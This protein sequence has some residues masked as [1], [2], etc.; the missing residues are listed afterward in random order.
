MYSMVLQV[1]GSNFNS[2]EKKRRERTSEKEVGNLDQMIKDYRHLVE[3]QQAEEVDLSK[4]L[5]VSKIPIVQIA[6]ML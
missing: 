3:K 4:D 1:C 6:M 2:S 5:D